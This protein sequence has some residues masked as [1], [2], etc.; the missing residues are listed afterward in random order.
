MQIKAVD[1][2]NI[3]FNPATNEFEANVVLKTAAGA[4]HYP[5]AVAGPMMMPMAMAAFKLTQQAKQ[6]HAAGDDLHT[7]SDAAITSEPATDF[8]MVGQLAA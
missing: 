6:R 4:F 3:R 5:C 7:R 1:Q 8:V 2:N